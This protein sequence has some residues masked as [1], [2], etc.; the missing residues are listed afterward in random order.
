MPSFAVVFLLQLRLRLL[1]QQPKQCP[2]A[3][4]Q[5][6]SDQHKQQDEQSG[7]LDK[8]PQLT[9]RS[10]SIPIHIDARS[11]P[12][13][14]PGSSSPCLPESPKAG[15]VGFFSDT[16]PGVST[17]GSS[18]GGA[19]HRL[20]SAAAAA[21]AV[22]SGGASPRQSCCQVAGAST[23]VLQKLIAERLGLLPTEE[24]KQMLH[25]VIP[26]VS[27]ICFQECTFLWSLSSST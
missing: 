6:V 5:H 1:H 8:P 12:S 3:D 23:H 10:S 11:G 2:L 15:Q 13:P 4:Q 20:G 7:W 25:Y 22:S 9:H 24:G 19:L 27:M 26:Q 18:A 16:A 14:T 17:S 21:L